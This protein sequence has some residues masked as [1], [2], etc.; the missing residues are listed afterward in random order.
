[1][2]THDDLAFAVAE[3]VVRRIRAGQPEW[4]DV[5]STD[6]HASRA[7]GW[8][9]PDFVLVDGQNDR[10]GAAE[11][12][13]PN[14]SKREYLTGLGQ[15]V[16]YTRDFDLALLV[17][18]TTSDDGYLIAE[19]IGSVLDQPALSEIP[20]GLL[21][22]D[23]ALLA[24]GRGD[25]SVR[26]SAQ[27]TAGPRPAIRP[28]VADSFW[29]KW[30]DISPIEMGLFLEALYEE[31]RP[32]VGSSNSGTVRDRAFDLL[33]AQMQS[34][35]TT[36]WGGGVRNVAN[37]PTSK[38]AW[39]KNYRNFIGHITWSLPDGNLTVEGLEAL[40]I[41]HQ[42]G[43]G[44]RVFLDQVANSVLIEGKHLL[45]INYIN[46]FQ[47]E[48]LGDRGPFENEQT[49]LDEVE[50]YL[51]AEGVLKRNPGRH[52]AAVQHAARAFLKAEKTLWR[53]LELF[54]PYGPGGGRAFHPGR[55]LRF[56]WARITT[57][58]G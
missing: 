52:A 31:G 2:S 41:F 30:R 40:R 57:L 29:C 58:L 34:G 28:D 7:R 20:L 24:P 50:A 32:G 1:M 54:V 26:R 17:V 13:P 19:H 15:A 11:F 44:S 33:W 21:E 48:R 6:I 56:D 10:Y 38:I 49:W 14:Q 35:A 18:P 39:S 27:L 23:P 16:A 53:N 46:R 51:E 25:F 45:L 9:L 22:Y 55:G 12:K 37:T 5:F 8:P 47:D 42:Y 36:H 43:P 3:E 4:S